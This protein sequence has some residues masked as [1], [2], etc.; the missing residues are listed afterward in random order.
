MAGDSTK[1][2]LTIEGRQGRGKVKESKNIPKSKQRKE[3]R[4]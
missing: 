1:I 3:G 2:M 4:T